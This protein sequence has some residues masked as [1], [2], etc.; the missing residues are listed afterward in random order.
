M[1]K[2]PGMWI[3]STTLEEVTAFYHHKYQ[4]VKVVPGLLKIIFEILD[5]SIDEAIRTD[6]KHAN[7][8]S[9]DIGIEGSI[10]ISDN[11]RGIPIVPIG[12]SYQPVLAW[13]K[14]RAGSNFSDEG[15]TTIGMN[16][17]GS[18]ATNVFSKEFRGVTQDSSGKRLIYESGENAT[19]Q[20]H[21][22]SKST[23]K[24]TGTSVYFIPDYKRF[25]VDN[26]FDG[27]HQMVISDRLHNLAIT[28]PKIKFIYNGVTISPYNPRDKFDNPM[29]INESV[30]WLIGIGLTD[31]NLLEFQHHSY[32]NGLHL[33]SGGS[34]VDYLIDTLV[35]HLRP[36]IS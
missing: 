6:F 19:Q 17:V 29:I 28:Y 2:R 34:H 23:K 27:D 35:S 25:N 13:S 4:V 7:E 31:Q 15:R 20:H 10:T 26:L 22:I 16:G 12:D 5:N 30:N 14:A 36:S 11:G 9:V 18:F 33:S 32:V 8:I 3:G 24:T 1:L 21:T